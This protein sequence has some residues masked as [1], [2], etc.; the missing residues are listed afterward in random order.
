[1]IVKNPSPKGKWIFVKIN[2][3]TTKKWLAGY[4][5]LNIPEADS[6]QDINLNS[7][8]EAV[9]KYKEKFNKYPGDIYTPEYF[10]TIAASESNTGG[11]T[12][13]SGGSVTV[14]AGK[15]YSLDIHT[16][17]NTYL[18]GY[19]IDG[20]VQSINT[21]SADTTTYILRKIEDDKDIIVG[22]AEYGS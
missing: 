17:S 9:L 1:M 10:Y 22:F 3:H 4:S 16:E 15:D 14:E 20:T 21:P 19:T 12:S 2:G 6:T 13:L 8:E 11:T 18:T 7:H 5:S